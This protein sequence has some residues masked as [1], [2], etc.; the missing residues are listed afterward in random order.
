MVIYGNEFTGGNVTVPPSKSAA[1]RALLC[2]VLSG[3]KTTVYNIDESRDME[4]TL[5]AVRSLGAHVVYEK[6]GK[7]VK[8]DASALGSV[9]EGEIDCIE[10]GSTLRFLIPV[11]AALGGTWRFT[12]RGRLPERPLGV[13][14]ELLPE[15]GVKFCSAGGLP[16]EVSGKLSSGSYCLP[17]NI[18]SQFIT[19]LLLAL[20]LLNGDSEIILTSPL[21]SKGYVEL[22][23]SVLKDYGIHVEA[24]ETGWHIPGSQTFTPREYTVEGDWSQA[25]FFLSMAALSPQGAKVRLHGL[26][27]DSVQGDKACL[28]RFGGFGLKTVW[29]GPV[30]AAWNPYSEKPYGGLQGYTINAAQI[31]D[32]VPALAVCAALCEGETRITHA[33]RLRLKESDRLAAMEQAI[34]A[35]GGRA[36]AVT[37]G[38][39]IQGVPFLRGGTALGQNDHRVVMSL[40]AG[41]LRSRGEI[42]V[43]EEQSIGK[44]YPGF[45]EDFR[46]LGG[47]A[48]V[49]HL[50]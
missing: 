23:C 46:K 32:M 50:G 17:G 49:V 31:P 43:T 24:T 34:N 27:P 41:A 1:H 38:L 22:T 8:V 2:A 6:S 25:A 33:E 16:L 15:H 37:D 29:E 13:Y 20:P 28:A 42:S 12:G 5:E 26:N 39:V 44:S 14:A 3:G 36:R 48:H 35:V 10:S 18:S 9:H 30:L 19:G 21:E 7:A 11:A 45:F 40:A 47:N 4:A